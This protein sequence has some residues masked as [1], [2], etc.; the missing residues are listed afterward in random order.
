[1]FLQASLF[2]SYIT[3]P[4]KVRQLLNLRLRTDDQ[5]S[6][7]AFPGASRLPPDVPLGKRESKSGNMQVVQIQLQGRVCMQAL[8]TGRALNRLKPAVIG[9][10]ATWKD[11]QR[12]ALESQQDCFTKLARMR[13]E[14]GMDK[15]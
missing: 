8:L 15:V 10:T 12:T 2:L 3:W 9:E 5:G 6:S 14:Q 11:G 13:D 1:M 7:A 4:G